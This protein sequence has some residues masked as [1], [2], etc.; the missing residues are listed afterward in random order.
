MGDQATFRTQM[1]EFG[2]RFRELVN[3]LVDELEDMAGEQLGEVK[4]VMDI[5][6]D[7][8]IVAET[9]GSREFRKKVEGVVRDVVLEMARAGLDA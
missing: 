3:R 8:N 7:E 4:A 6:R 9:E 1:D 5:V 2:K